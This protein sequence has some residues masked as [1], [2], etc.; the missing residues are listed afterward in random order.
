ML[1]RIL[2]N[3]LFVN[4]CG[5]SHIQ[6]IF[7]LQQARLFSEKDSHD[8]FK[9]KKKT[10]PTGMDDVMKVFLSYSHLRLPLPFPI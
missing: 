6:K 9:P 7:S 5:S 8:D 2:S 4:K 10:I 1:R 3:N